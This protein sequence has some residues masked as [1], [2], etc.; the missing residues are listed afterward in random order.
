MKAAARPR[1]SPSV[2]I[3]NCSATAALEEN[4]R[5]RSARADRVVS[6]VRA[7]QGD[8]LLFSSGHFCACSP[9]AGSG[10]MRARGIPA[11]HGEPE[12]GGLREQ[13]VRAGDPAV[14]RD[15]SCERVNRHA[16]AGAMGGRKA[17]DGYRTRSKCP[18]E[19]NGDESE[20]ATSLSQ[21]D[22]T[23]W[24]QLLRQ[25]GCGPVRVHGNGQR[26]LRAPSRLRQRRR[27]DDC[28]R[29]ASASRPSPAPC[30]T[31]SRSA[32]CTP[33]RPTSARTPSASTTSRWSFSSAA[34]WPTM[35]R[36]F[37]S[38]PSRSK[39]SSRRTSI[40]SSCSKQE[41]DAGLGN[42]GLGRLAACFLDS[43]ATM[44]L[45]A[46]GYGLRYEYGIF[47]QSIQDGWQHE[48]PDNW[49]RRPDPWEVARPHETGGSQAQLLVRGARRDLAR[50]PRPAVHPDRH[51]VRSPR[52]RL[53]RQDDQHAAP[54]GRGGARLLR[55]P[56]VQQRRFRRRA[57]RDAR[58]R[59]ADARALS[60]RLHQ[61]GPGTALRA[62]VFSGRLLAGRSRAP[63]PPQQR[64]LEHAAR[65]GRHPAQRHA[66]GDGRPRADAHPARR[67]APRL[68]PGLGPHAD[69]RWPTRTTRCCP[70][71]WRN[72]RSRGSS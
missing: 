50:R 5:I 61:P 29:R 33:R 43:M 38:I 30:A 17:T 55:L 18:S 16:V 36:T 52:R 63:L 48:Q 34:R 10:S 45:P 2:P 22:P 4:R 26:A 71:L 20:M 72:G 62:G 11:E 58:G 49:L 1:S 27:P 65:E 70:R 57:G 39:P 9:L 24:R 3:G 47:Q 64:R 68:G 15:S 41:P 67:G 37:C 7:V 53:R 13:P 35:S 19:R 14:E 59:I 69:G 51:P 56:G 54:L 12:R 25:Y 66:P 31:S 40:G 8:V 42:G 32:G 6:R 21:R 44:Q 23:L 60:R 46:M 28:R